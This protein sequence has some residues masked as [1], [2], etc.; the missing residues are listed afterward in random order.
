[1]APTKST[2]KKVKVK[3]AKSARRAKSGT[4]GTPTAQQGQQNAIPAD[5]PPVVE[6]GYNR[7]AVEKAHAGFVVGDVS[8]DEF[9]TTTRK[10]T[11]RRVGWKFRGTNQ[12]GQTEDDITQIAMAKMWEALPTFKD[13]SETLVPCKVLD[14][15]F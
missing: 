14:S 2:K 10:F 12:F 7:D 9:L 4:Q 11:R 3:R 6:V 5:S 13:T 1:M 15:F 8:E